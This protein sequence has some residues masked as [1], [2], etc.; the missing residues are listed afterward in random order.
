[1]SLLD[2]KLSA[3][4]NLD[5]KSKIDYHVGNGCFWLGYKIWIYRVTYT[6]SSAPSDPGNRSNN[7]SQGSQRIMNIDCYGAFSK[8]GIH[9]LV[10]HSIV[11]SILNDLV[12]N[13]KRKEIRIF[14]SS[15]AWL[16]RF[17][18]EHWKSTNR[19]PSRPLKYIFMDKNV[20]E[21]I[22]HNFDTF[23][24]EK[25]EDKKLFE[26]LGSK[27]K[28]VYMLEGESSTGKTNVITSLAHRYSSNLCWVN[29]QKQDEED[30]KIILQCVPKSSMIVFEDIKP[31]T[32]REYK[33]ESNEG[34]PL[35]T[36]LNILDGL[37]S[38]EGNI[39]IM[40][41]NYFQEL[42]DFSPELLREGRVDEIVK[43]KHIDKEQATSMFHA[44]T[45]PETEFTELASESLEQGE[46]FGKLLDGM[47]VRDSA[48]QK[49]LLRWIRDS[50]G[51]FD[52]AEEWLE[53][54]LAEKSDKTKTHNNEA[55]H[56]LTMMN[57]IKTLE[58]TG[59]LKDS[60]MVDRSRLG[61]DDKEVDKSRM[62]DDV[63]MVDESNSLSDG[64]VR[65]ESRLADD[66]KIVDE[67]NSLSDGK[68]GT[69][70]RLADDTKI[71]DES[72]SLSDGKVGT[73]N[74]LVDD[75]ETAGEIKV[76]DVSGIK[77]KWWMK[78]IERVRSRRNKTG[79]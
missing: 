45:N 47:K 68:V 8:K 18:D 51:A 10:C 23:Y 7:Q 36:F 55:S 64:K 39:I 42:H 17:R 38:P 2:N 16:Y 43:F 30:L 1:M 65:T 59:Q 78:P 20:K 44:Y 67:S 11:I 6:E 40:T 72:N 28:L 5:L 33:P 13:S 53:N 41:T 3:R 22:V 46:K 79:S 12:L 70:N 60:V 77:T 4:D 73:E 25:N 56:G 76:E 48:V 21:R 31:S 9:D 52:H 75:T 71:V 66:T 26:E 58:E 15:D 62:A 34:F 27:H 29:L 69:E 32:F 61:T 49:Y 50:K 19:I 24:S 37:I 63:K 57:D 14:E 74:R 35:S 54:L